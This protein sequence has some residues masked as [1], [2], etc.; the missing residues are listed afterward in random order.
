M[1][2]ICFRFPSKFVENNTQ[3]FWMW[4]HMPAV[5]PNEKL[6]QENPEFQDSLG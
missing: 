3:T 2:R 5:L 4:G 6:R 1:I